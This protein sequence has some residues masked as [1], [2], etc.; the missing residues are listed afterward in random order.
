MGSITIEKQLLCYHCGEECLA[1]KIVAGDKYF[2]CEGCKI[3]FQLI[4][5]QGLCEYYQL[6]EQPGTSR[7]QPA[8]EN[9]FA[10]LDD[11][12]IRNQLISFTDD[13]ETH[14]TFYLPQVHCSSCLYLLE[15]LHK[16]EPAIISSRVNFARKEATII[17]DPQKI[18][19]RRV[20]GLLTEIGYEPHISLG[21]LGNK[22]PGPSRSLIYR[23]GVAGFCFANSMLFSFPEYLG[24]E[25]AEKNLQVAFRV[26]NLLVALPVFFYSAWPFF[27]AGWKGI[28]SKFLN[29]DAPIALAILVTFL[30]SIYEVLSGTGGGYFD[31][32]TGIV[33]FMLMGRVLQDKTYQQLS[34]DRDYTS[35][36]PI[37]VS[38]LKNDK[39]I[40][41]QLPD[42]KTGDTILVHNEE[43]VPADGILVRGKAFIDYSFVTGESTLVPKNT[44]EIIYAGGKQSGGTCELMLVKEVAQSYLTSLWSKDELRKDARHSNHSFVHRVSQYFTWVVLAVAGTASAYWWI[45]DSSKILDAATAVL[46]V[47]CPCAL[48]LSNTFTNG[49]ILRILARNGFYLRSAQTIEDIAGAHQIVFDKTGTLTGA[50]AQQVDYTGVPLTAQQQQLVGALAAQSS[51]PLSKQVAAYFGRNTRIP[52]EDFGEIPGQGIA[53]F[54]NNE[55]VALGS[56]QFITGENGNAAHFQEVFVA[57]ENKTYGA[58]SFRNQYRDEMPALVAKLSQQH[59]LSVISGDNEAEKNRLQQ[60]L[61][62]NAV[63]LFHQ[64]PEDKLHFIKQLQE[65]GEKVIMIGDGLNDAGA[66]KQSDAGIAVTEDSNN[67]TPSSDAILEARHLPKLN[68][69]M[70]LCRANKRIV[71]ASFILSMLYNIIGLYFAV[72][73]SLSPLVAAI[74]MPSSS[75]SILLITFGGSNLAAR[76]LKL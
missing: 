63:L 62:G 69:F 74:L 59:C 71:M 2:C 8:R 16:L 42:L 46:I 61:G 55:L 75:L 48:L 15:N 20:A 45:Y 27:F 49:N 56:K 23:L 58:F 21:D 1:G 24:L 53:G 12:G 35:Y 67:F 73:G 31:S 5:R 22:K 25:G 38:V 64:S 50:H 76:W 33:F 30:R 57:I 29:I 19:L 52:V 65:K 44:G 9:K 41:T 40:P 26:M 13:N 72:Q 18:T 11:P 3:V 10:F 34:F 43:L 14:I 47:A 60:M 17:F 32:M 39:E 7:K 4:N 51:H 6:N 70:Q 37:A 36:F 54:V 66:L 68:R 28:R